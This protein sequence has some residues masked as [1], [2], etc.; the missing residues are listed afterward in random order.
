MKFDL[1]VA[2]EGLAALSLL[3][4]LASGIK[5][6][7]ISR[8]RFDEPSSYWAQAGISAVFS[9]DDDFE[10]HVSDTLAAGDGLC[11]SAALRKDYPCYSI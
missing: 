9:A 3:F 1:L 8:N 5:E 2:G 4:N 10:K 11:N 7:G 6:G